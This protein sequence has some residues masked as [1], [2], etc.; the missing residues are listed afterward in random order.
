MKRFIQF[1]MLLSLT[2][3]LI[4]CDGGGKSSSPTVTKS[5]KPANTQTYTINGSLD[6]VVPGTKLTLLD[7][8]G[9][10]LTAAVNGRFQFPTAL[11]NGATYN[12]TVDAQPKGQKCSVIN[13]KGVVD[14]SNVTNI[15]V[16]CIDWPFSSSD[17]EGDAQ[18]AL[19]KIPLSDTEPAFVGTQP[20]PGTDE[21]SP[22]MD[23]GASAAMQQAFALASSAKDPEPR[24][25]ATQLTPQS[26]MMKP[27]QTINVQ[28]NKIDSAGTVYAGVKSTELS[29]KVAWQGAD[30]TITPDEGSAIWTG[31][32]ELQVTSPANLGP[33]RLLVALRPNSTDPAVLADTERWSALFTGEEWGLQTG[34]INLSGVGQV[35]YPGTGHGSP[36]Q[37][38]ASD[39]LAAVKA[40]QR[41]TFDKNVLGYPVVISGATAISTGESVDLR[42]QG[43]PAGGTV[44]SVATR[45]I[46]QML[47]VQLDPA[48]A[49]VI[50]PYDPQTL[51]N[52]GLLPQY[53][54]WTSSVGGLS[55]AAA[56]SGVSGGVTAQSASE[57]AQTVSAQGAN[58]LGGDCTGSTGASLSV[59]FTPVWNLA[60]WDVGLFV[61]PK[62]A[63]SASA[64]C[65][66]KLEPSKGAA[67]ALEAAFS[68]PLYLLL[69]PNFAPKPYGELKASLSMDGNQDD[70][71]SVVAGYSTGQ[72]SRFRIAPLSNPMESLKGTSITIKP[73][74]TGEVGVKSEIENGIAGGAVGLIF[75]IMNKLGGNTSE[76]NASIKAYVN[77]G[78]EATLPDAAAVY[79]TSKGSSVKAAAKAG[80]AATIPGFLAKLISNPKGKFDTSVT[81]TDV[82]LDVAYQAKAEAQST[83]STKITQLT[84]TET[85][86]LA[87]LVGASGGQ[88]G[89]GRMAPKDTS[90]SFFDRIVAQG[91]T[92]AATEQEC[93][94]AGGKLNAPIVA[95]SISTFFG[96]S[97][98]I[99]ICSPIMARIDATYAI[100]QVNQSV[101]SQISGAIYAQTPLPAQV[102]YNGSGGP[103]SW[104]DSKQVTESTTTISAM[105][106]AACSAPGVFR[107][108]NT[109]NVTGLDQPV[110]SD[111]VLVCSQNPPWIFGD[112][113]IVLPGGQSYDFQ[114]TGD[115][116]LLQS[117]DQTQ[118]VQAHFD[119]ITGTQG[120]AATRLAVKI[121]GDILEISTDYWAAEAGAMNNLFITLNGQPLVHGA[122]HGGIMIT[123]FRSLN[124]PAGPVTNYPLPGGG[125]L[126]ALTSSVYTADPNVAYPTQI[127]ISW[128]KAPSA[129]DGTPVSGL[130]ISI[131]QGGYTQ[132]RWL[133]FYPVT[134][135]AQSGTLGGM[136]GD[137]ANSGYASLVLPNG[138]PLLANPGDPLTFMDV[139]A[140]LGV[141]WAVLSGSS[142]L[143]AEGC[144]A[145]GL[146]TSPV[147]L[148]GEQLALGEQA[149][150]S[151]PNGYLKQACITDVGLTG[152]PALAQSPV[153]QTLPGGSSS[154]P[155]LPPTTTT[156][157]IVLTTLPNI[158]FGQNNGY[159]SV[160]LSLLA[161]Q[162]AGYLILPINM[163]SASS[164]LLDGVPLTNDGITGTL[165]GGQTSSHN[166]TL[167]CGPQGGLGQLDVVP[168]DPVTQTAE[169]NSL[170]YT[171][172]ICGTSP[173]MQKISTPWSATYAVNSIGEVWAWGG[174]GSGQL[175]NGM[176]T[177]SDVPVLVQFPSILGSNIII[178][179][180]GGY[181]SAYAL[182]DSGHVWAWGYNGDDELGNGAT[183]NSTVPVLVQ[184]PSSLGAYTI[185][186]I[187]V[188]PNATTAY[189][190]D[191]HGR[192]WVWGDN[193][194]FEYGN[195]TS[196]NS[197][198]PV[199]AGSPSNLGSSVI[200]SVTGDSSEEYALD[201]QG[202]L[203]TWGE[204]WFT[205]Y[206]NPTYI[207]QP[208]QIFNGAG[209]STIASVSSSSDSFGGYAIDKL[210]R[211]WA[212]GQNTA[213]SL[214]NGTKIN[215]A[216]PVLVEFPAS[217]NTDSI[218]SAVGS[219]DSAYAIDSE[220]RLWA[221][222]S[223]SFGQLGNGTTVDSTVPELVK[224]P[225]SLGASTIVKVVYDGAN[226]LAYAIDSQGR[227]WV[228]GATGGSNGSIPGLMQFP[229]SLGTSAILNVLF[230]SNYSDFALDDSGQIWA[231]GGSGNDTGQFGN[232]SKVPS[233]VPVMVDQ[234]QMGPVLH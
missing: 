46:E 194:S 230:N 229:A 11:V 100:A 109:L 180:S 168:I 183:V 221:W 6:G 3:F 158:V 127:L 40:F 212:W 152:D 172:L 223:N 184:F 22:T 195:G 59:Q 67:F 28:V 25:W 70:G 233:S 103:L 38:T 153:Y 5:P 225:A 65:T 208:E 35:L 24:W 188:S 19:D 9:D 84:N 145:P 33:G 203:W 234:S 232:G 189:A 160:T 140:K 86:I 16:S 197:A 41:A 190:L 179:V 71:F 132:P 30:G 36:T 60:S 82:G 199:L 201:S 185:S 171:S 69:G 55:T 15:Q 200:I 134:T 57:N 146:P 196:A 29:V 143:F 44:Y 117:A 144:S 48:A 220:G 128:P 98:E 205:S 227:L 101:Q 187:Y 211:L 18:T 80:V 90:L 76:F 182:D 114:A 173:V 56:N 198:V 124:N 110:T 130:I 136:L 72:G 102:S 191:D 37:F 166:L 50:P 77:A 47:I 219:D 159:K 93:K 147:M 150:A 115:F 192:L 151:L 129:V 54:I 174:G 43:Y 141:A 1:S 111:N 91:D 34:T 178:S 149:C 104:S 12:V 135:D 224:F 17:P 107:G 121:G 120:T 105:A 218:V 87:M 51:I 204:N 42:L 63:A 163:P 156:P 202:R 4:A 226:A 7:N 89:I 222:G 58:V 23:D 108:K 157:N 214:G 137:G 209:S 231:W 68:G 193:S 119:K 112:P 138:Q 154:N 175:G 61:S 88:S 133:N 186:S 162:M 206:G 170:T 213:G 10:A 177:N 27:G 95:S 126:S 139:Y 39:M 83:N 31:T 73:S 97:N 116:T 2:L 131:N 13:G 49:Y 210:G 215:S 164:L 8:G 217:L 32:G 207:R 99:K 45:G 118:V 94:A 78:V 64:S 79:Q 122:A 53:P 113:H 26:Q 216:V 81:L 165:V 181:E 62:I 92:V 14:S 176:T 20:M 125:L 169:L 75:D 96:L 167:Q 155:I 106:T 228:W 21:I 123:P 161:D 66:W 142:C 74:F 148:T 85:G 52:D